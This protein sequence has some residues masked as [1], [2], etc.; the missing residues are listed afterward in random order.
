MAHI[1]EDFGEK[2]GGAKKDLW[3][4]RGILI[5]DLND[6]T[7]LE[8]EEFVKK[9]NIWIVNEWTEYKGSR[10]DYVIYFIKLVRDKLPAK[11]TITKSN[12]EKDREIA[13]KYIQFIREV[14]EYCDNTVMDDESIRTFVKQFLIKYG[15]Y[16][17]GSGYTDKC[18]NVSILSSGWLDAVR[19]SKYELE[20]LK[21]ECRVQRFPEEFRGDLK[22]CYVYRS[23][24][25][26]GYVV[27][28]GDKTITR[29]KAFVT[30][31]EAYEF[32]DTALRELLDKVKEAK[33]V[34]RKGSIKVVRPQ[35]SHIART[36]GDI[37]KGEDAYSDI[38]LEHFK[39]RAGEFGNWNSDKD[40]QACLNY[41]FDAFCDLAYLLDLPLESMG[42]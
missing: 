31:E 41:A 15:Y 18:K 6:I 38:F 30:E 26:G 12:S 29:D 42:L 9:D 19:I 2:I 11:V 7:D 23:S 20:R 25:Y 3:K 28:K 33:A 37:R 35:L 22:G 10:P 5:E 8:I 40:R 17:E 34:T 4:S 1:I 32:C 39:F 36:G 27:A 24:Y 21:S 14:K 13:A 16:E